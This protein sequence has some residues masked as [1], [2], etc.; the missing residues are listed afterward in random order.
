M[1]QEAYKLIKRKKLKSIDVFYKRYGKKLLVY[2]IKNW[3]TDEDTA[4]ELIYKTLYSIVDK[5]DNYDFR[6][7]EKFGSFVLVT[8]LNNLRD[9]YRDNKKLIK[10]ENIEDPERYY[11]DKNEDDCKKSD[12]SSIIILKE[13]LEK[14]EE[15]EKMLLLLRAQNMPYNDIAEYIDKPKEHLK[16]YYQR[17]KN[18][19]VNNINKKEKEVQ[20]G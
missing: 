7:E 19:I 12:S 18:K 16:V 20:N 1:K 10:T 6:S 13:E 15:W 14:L 17:L 2:A 3:G 11:N 4:W 5:I 8:F 9:K